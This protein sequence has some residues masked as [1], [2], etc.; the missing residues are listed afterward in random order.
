[1]S[2]L[3]H[4]PIQLACAEAASPEERK[5]RRRF[6]LLALAW[7]VTHLLSSVG[8]RYG[9]DLGAPL[10]GL[11]ALAPT[12]VG[13]VAIRTFLR[14]LAAADELQR[15]IHLD[16]TAWGFGA[17]FLMLSGYGQL[18]QAGAPPVALSLL[19][20]LMLVFW[21]LAIVVARRRYR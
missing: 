6:A 11:I 9:G 17:A 20:S 8:L 5:E 3:E 1:M 10:R 21:A 13:L 2:T 16:A 12:L 15:R 4:N 7:G 19:G 14:F 18:E